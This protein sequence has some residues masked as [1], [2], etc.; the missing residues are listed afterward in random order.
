MAMS[1]SFGIQVYGTNDAT[2]PEFSLITMLLATL[3]AGGL[4]L[5]V[6]RR[7]K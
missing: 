2:V 3:L 7:R 6:V 4:V 1:G 5:F